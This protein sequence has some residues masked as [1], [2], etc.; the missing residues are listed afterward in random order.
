[1]GRDRRQT[2]EFRRQKFCYLLSALHDPKIQQFC[3]GITGDCQLRRC[4]EVGGEVGDHFIFGFVSELI[5]RFDP[6]GVPAATA[7]PPSLKTCRT[8]DFD[9]A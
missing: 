7:F 5:D 4:R 9:T 6:E 3:C 2:A 8:F 1:M